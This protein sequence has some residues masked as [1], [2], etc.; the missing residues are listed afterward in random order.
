M[1]KIPTQIVNTLKLFKKNLAEKFR[2][3][4]IILFGSFAK[5]NYRENSD[6]DVCV[7]IEKNDNNFLSMLQ[8]APIAAEIDTR[9]E[10]VVFSDEEYFA[11]QSFGIL[12]DIKTTGIVIE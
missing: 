8:V 2:V 4:K 9:I 6:I 10:A 5:G 3:K 12:K 11:E 1:D 7:I